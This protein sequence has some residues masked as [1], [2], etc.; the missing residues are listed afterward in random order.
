MTTAEPMA[1]IAAMRDYAPEAIELLRQVAAH[2]HV[3]Q[4]ELS[5]A[6]S[7]RIRKLLREIDKA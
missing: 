5:V 1:E 2:G 7:W 4:S 3:M 6:L